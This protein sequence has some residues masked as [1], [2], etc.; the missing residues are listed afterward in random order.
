MRPFLP[1]AALAVLAACADSEPP[2]AA[3]TDDGGAYNMVDPVKAPIADDT[4]PA[5]GQWIQSMQD[6]RPVL[7]FGPANTEPLFS[8]RCD[9][10][11][12]LLLNRHGTLATDGGEM[13]SVTIGTASRNLAVNP[14]PGPLPKLRAAVPAQDELLEQLAASQQPIRISMG[15]GPPLVLPT[16]PAIGE[17][18][19]SCNNPRESRPAPA[20]AGE[21]GNA[22]QNSTQ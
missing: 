22:T 16:D 17:F 14:V 6:E 13:M 15:D 5:I 8:L 21:E 7:Q 2:D 9:D 10:R 4:E 12:G 1:L 11:G 19:E 20:P 3:P 18:I